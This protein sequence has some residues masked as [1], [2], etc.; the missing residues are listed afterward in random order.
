MLKIM[1]DSGLVSITFGVESGDDRVLS[2]IRKATT[3][4]NHKQALLACKE[5]GIPLRCS[6][7]YGNPG[8]NLDSVKNTI[9]L[10]KETQ[11]GEWNLA[12]LAPIPG[13]DIWDY[14]E[15]YGVI[16]D[17]DWVRSKDYLITNRFD[18]SGIGSV[19]IGLKGVSKEE[20]AKN[21]DYLVTELEKVCPRKKIQDTIQDINIKK[22]NILK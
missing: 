5:L 17:K 2:N 11:P 1:K 18:T 13:S 8:E 9:Q 3:V 7:M 20:F 12:V 21:L 19:W 10:I 22:I 4:A 15:K 16:F 6:I 14:P